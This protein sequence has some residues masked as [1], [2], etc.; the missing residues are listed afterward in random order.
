MRILPAFF[1]LLIL[2]SCYPEKLHVEKQYMRRDR[3]A[4]V[5]VGTPDPKK[6]CPSLGERLL[7][8]WRLREEFKCQ[9][10]ISIRLK[11]VLRNYETVEKVFPVPCARGQLLYYLM[12]EDYDC[13]G[14]IMAYYATLE[15]ECGVIAEQCHQ[16]WTS[17]ILFD[18]EP[19]TPYWDPEPERI[20]YEPM[21]DAIPWHEEAV[22]STELP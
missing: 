5:Y 16:L 6:Y 13:T 17:L 11:L 4:S 10:P 8:R 15:G 21:N 18:D 14:G 1:L 19:A 9:A 3:Y 22:E 2:T 12:D 7:I 20:Y